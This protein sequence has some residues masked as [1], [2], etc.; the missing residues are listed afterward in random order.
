MEL[1]TCKLHLLCEVMNADALQTTLLIF[2]V[3]HLP[4]PPNS[5]LV[6]YIMHTT[7]S[8]CLVLKNHSERHQGVGGWV[9]GWSGEE[10][11]RE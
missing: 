7:Y 6:R 11:G 3:V 9:G 5:T 8:V 2:K 4:I 1:A 10:E